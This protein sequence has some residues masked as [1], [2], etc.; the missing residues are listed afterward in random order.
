MSKTLSTGIGRTFKTRLP[1]GKFSDPG[2]TPGPRR[3]SQNLG[4]DGRGLAYMEY[5]STIIGVSGVE[6]LRPCKV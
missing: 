4:S 5:F 3:L 2:V 6:I 1:L